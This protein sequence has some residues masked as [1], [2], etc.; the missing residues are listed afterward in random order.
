MKIKGYKDWTEVARNTCDD[1]TQTIVYK[2]KTHHIYVFEAPYMPG[3]LRIY[4]SPIC[5]CMYAPEIYIGDSLGEKFQHIRIG[6]TSFGSLEVAEIDKLIAAYA[7]A[8][9]AAREIEEAFPQCFGK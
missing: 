8:Q 4:A 6:T 5:K 9:L 7:E 3:G 1:G 2:T